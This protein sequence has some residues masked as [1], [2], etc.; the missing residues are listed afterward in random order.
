MSFTATWRLSWRLA[1]RDLRGGFVGL[2]IFLSCLA[3][4]VAA[5][6]GVGS[7]SESILTGLKSDARE[8]LGGDVELRRSH[9]PLDEIHR[10][11]LSGRVA[12]SSDTV[13]MRAMASPLNDASRTLIELKAV[14]AAFPLFGAV[15][16]D[17]PMSLDLALAEGGAVVDPVLLVRL[18]VKVGDVVRVGDGEFTIRA[19]LI[20]EPDRLATAFSF[21]PRLVISENSLAA[22]GLIQPGSL[23]RYHT[24]LALAPD[25]PI[26]DFVAQLE[27]AFPDADWR[28]R[29]ARNAQPGFRSFVDRL[30]TYLIL[31]GLTALLVGGIGV[32]GAVRGHVDSRRGTIAILKCLGAP[33]HLVFTIYILQVILVAAV[34]TIIGIGLGAMLPTL[35]APL[36]A[37]QMPVGPTAGLYVRP[38]VTAALFGGLTALAAALW[39]IAKS[40]NVPAGSL[41]RQMVTTGTTLPRRRY[42]VALAVLLSVLAALAVVGA[43]R[44][45]IGVG[46]VAGVGAALVVFLIAS[47]VLIR[48]LRSIAGGLTGVRRFAVNGLVRPGADTGIVLLSLGIGLSVLVAIALIEGNLQSRISDRLPDTVP[49]FFFIDIQPHQIGPFRQD[50]AALPGV[51]ALE[52]VPMVRGRII[53][54]NDVPVSDAPIE[55]DAQWLVRS[56]IGFT[57]A[58]EPPE[59]A[60]I[61]EGDWWPTGYQG[62]PIISFDAEGAAGMGV[63]VGDRLTFTIL[64]KQIQARISN[65]RAIDW[66]DFGINF[67]VIFAPGT[68]EGAPHSHIATAQATAAAEEQLV[69]AVGEGFANVSAIPVR[70]MIET[71]SRVVTGVSTALRATAAITLLAGILVLAGVIAADQRR[72]VFESVVL[73]VLGADRRR[74]ASMFLIEFA[75][76]GLLAGIIASGVGTA[77]AW[78][79]VT[80][81]MEDQWHFQAERVAITVMVC[82]LV[83]MVVGLGLTW[84][85]LS[86]KPMP[87]LRTE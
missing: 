43:G 20:S 45:W 82:I 73:K 22:T 87:I 6:A 79:F 71:V 15:T 18:N 41:F 74:I 11:W 1:L 14:D 75:I 26:R 77:G 39:P 33:A 24:R 28:R 63:G 86:Q 69:K 42:L 51:T 78:V 40:E 23:I 72:R 13:Q 53:A 70:S 4:G 61:V 19:A 12:R 81:V 8:I 34:G 27:N 2:P 37:D 60:N 47:W 38:M 25:V 58:A 10:H 31:V 66:N 59:R 5:I 54:I 67:V 3:I 30:T 85:T 84:R 44:P 17:P 50:V 83:T 56:D 29:D 16:I 65:L 64:G 7:L 32:A 76:L 62:E 68:L 57:Y 36:L 52:S 21:G 55:S 80:K 46:F 48:S 35:V 9:R 49:S